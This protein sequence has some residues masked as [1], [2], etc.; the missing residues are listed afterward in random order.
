MVQILIALFI[1]YIIY[2]LI[3]GF[4]RKITKGLKRNPSD[5]VALQASQS[6]H[7]ASSTVNFRSV[8]DNQSTLLDVEQ[9]SE[10]TEADFFDSNR[11]D[12]CLPPK[13]RKSFE[14]AFNHVFPQYYDDWPLQ[15][16]HILFPKANL[17][18]GNINHD[19]L[20]KIRKKIKKVQGTVKPL[21]LDSELFPTPLLIIDNSTSSQLKHGI[22][23][24][25]YEHNNTLF[26][27]K[28]YGKTISIRHYDIEKF[29]INE[30]SGLLSIEY[31]DYE[32]KKFSMYIDKSLRSTVAILEYVFDDYLANK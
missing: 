3:S 6:I 10:S 27:K 2:R 4:F 20:E 1:L 13:K 19:D 22:Y 5:G 14:E 30:S 7:A 12:H 17:T 28:S 29:E 31:Y 32:T 11:F 25:G 9:P 21:K 23:I 26:L 8:E 18:R 24:D 15:T 16:N